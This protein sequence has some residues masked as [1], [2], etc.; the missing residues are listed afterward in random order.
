MRSEQQRYASWVIEK[1]VKECPSSEVLNDLMGKMDQELNWKYI[2][3]R[4]VKKKKFGPWSHFEGSSPRYGSFVSR[5][6]QDRLETERRR[7]MRWQ[8][9][10]Q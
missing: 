1:I 8:S 3:G 9:V 6:F 4:A 5:T 2:N 10:T 7:S